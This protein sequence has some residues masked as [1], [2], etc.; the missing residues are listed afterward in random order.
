VKCTPSLM[1]R[2]PIELEDTL[3]LKTNNQSE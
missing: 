2:F 1:F 3:D